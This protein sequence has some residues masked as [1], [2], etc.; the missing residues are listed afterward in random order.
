MT[1]EFQSYRVIDPIMPHEVVN[2]QARQFVDGSAHTNTIEGF[3]SLG[4]VDI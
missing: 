4:S 1:D 3:W 2:H